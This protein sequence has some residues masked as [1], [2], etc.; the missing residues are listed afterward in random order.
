MAFWMV[1]LVALVAVV[2]VTMRLLKDESL[3]R[4]RVDAELH[5]TRTP[6][7]QYVVP[8]GDD[9]VIVMAALER[10][11]YTAV[12]DS[13][14]THQV[15]LV[16]CPDGVESARSDVRRVIERAGAVAPPIE[17]RPR[18]DVHFLDE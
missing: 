11:G 18:T 15:V 2:V 17:V 14:G 12:V 4:E 7:L 9:P 10:A 5:D 3:V 6:S 8:T 13:R 16:K 1:G